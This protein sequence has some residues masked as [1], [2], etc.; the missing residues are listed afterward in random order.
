MELK[1]YLLKIN[2]GNLS[3]ITLSWFEENKNKNLSTPEKFDSRKYLYS[4]VV[5]LFSFFFL[6]FIPTH[7]SFWLSLSDKMTTRK[8]NFVYLIVKIKLLELAP[9]SLS[10]AAPSTDETQW[11]VHLSFNLT[12]QLIS[13]VSS[14]LREPLTYFNGT[15]IVAFSRNPLAW[16]GLVY[17]TVFR[18]NLVLY[19]KYFKIKL[20]RFFNIIIRISCFLF[21][22]RP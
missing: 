3:F 12:L 2:P 21:R 11:F 17:A 9:S 6:I 19:F 1:T 4:F 7:W 18:N 16:F 20:Q 15:R 10:L 14:D 13:G 22:I 8:C 5:L